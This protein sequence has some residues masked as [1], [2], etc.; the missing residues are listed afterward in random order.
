MYMQTWN[1]F[2]T[3]KLLRLELGTF[4][5]TIKGPCPLK[6]RESDFTGK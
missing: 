6:E 2:G 3:F 4:K 5:Q 1:S